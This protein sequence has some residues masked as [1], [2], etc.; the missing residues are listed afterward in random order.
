MKRPY[1]SHQT[2]QEKSVPAPVGGLNTRDGFAGMPDTD[3]VY[4]INWVPDRGGVRCRKGYREWF[5]NLALPVRSIF[6]FFGPTTTFPGGSFIGLPTTMPG[7][8][9]AATDAGIYD[10][11]TTGA[12]P[13]LVQALSSGAQS[14][15]LSSAQVTNSGGSFLLV[16]S[17]TDGYYT[18]DGTTWV[19]VTLGAG[20]TQVSVV[21]PTTFSRV[22]VWKRR[23]WFVVKDTTRAAY[24]A[25]DAV[26]GAAASFDFGPVFKSGGKLAFITNWTIDAGEGI[27][28]FLVAVSNLGD[29][30]VYKGTDPASATTFAL[31]GTWQIGQIPEGARGFCQFGGDII[32]MGANGLYPISYVTRGGADLLVASSKEYT[33]KISPSIGKD[34][35]DSFTSR[36]W[37]LI[38]HPTE[39]LLISSVPNYTGL[40][41]RQ[42]AMSTTL[43]EWTTLQNVPAVCLAWHAGF[44]FTGDSEGR[45][46]LAFNG[47]FDNVPLGSTTGEGIEGAIVPAFSQFGIPSVEKQFVRVRPVFL[48]VDAPAVTCDINVN[49][50]LA[51]PS[52]A[53]VTPT[54]VLSVWN[55]GLWNSAL[56]SGAQKVYDAW[57]DSGETGYAATCFI[58]TVCAGDTVM[59]QVDYVFR[60]G[61][62]TGAG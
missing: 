7:F 48:S 6:G 35:Q 15:W 62:A 2:T 3:A 23:A 33:S 13:A 41:D 27:D 1:P 14:G 29:V 37:Q 10:V 17:E 51:I 45:V 57:F 34:L 32:L 36:G 21:D 50:Q 4:M 40:S 16:S 59:S 18:F 58:K 44:M 24:L 55:T 26:Y 19:K 61:K 53:V 28:D 25:A 12:V 43:M 46:L 30:A 38:V 60:V 49:Y 47:F 5:T 20:P 42:Y 56:W 22:A 11:T 52:G 31:V 39:R 8:L 54:S 9:F